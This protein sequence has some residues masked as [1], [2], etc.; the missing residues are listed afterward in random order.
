[1]LSDHADWEGLNWAIKQT[2]AENIFVK[3][4]Y[5]SILTRWLNSKGF[6]AKEVA[7][8]EEVAED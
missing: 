4:G 5:K 2:S 6:N 8:V 7:E 1:V 3:H